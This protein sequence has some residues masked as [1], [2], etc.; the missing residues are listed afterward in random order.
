VYIYSYGPDT[1]EDNTIHQDPAYIPT[2]PY[3]PTNGTVS[4]GE[5]FIMVKPK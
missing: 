2:V 1:D 3:D 5:L 4:A